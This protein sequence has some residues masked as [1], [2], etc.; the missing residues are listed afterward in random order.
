MDPIDCQQTYWNGVAGTKTFTHPLLTDRLGEYVPPDGKILDYGC[1]YGRTCAFLRE[2]GYGQAVGVDISA[3]MIREGLAL[4][5]GLDLRHIQG[6]PL[7]FPDQAFDACLLLAVLNCIPTD[8]GQK[9][10]M[11][12]LSRVL[13]PG[14]ILYLSDYPLQ[15]DARNTERYDRFESEFGIY[16]V[17]RLSEGAVFR[18]HD[19]AWIYELLS[20]LD[21]VMEETMDVL[22][23]NGSRAAIFQIMAKKC[24]QRMPGQC[25]VKV[26]R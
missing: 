19:M 5:P 7:P 21:I 10:L 1:G 9:D 4:H 15:T 13:R 8:N 14:G 20:P 22:T 18:H 23:M 6:G 16:G 3:A 26:D 12:E 2:S 17:F 25:F 24:S 11:R